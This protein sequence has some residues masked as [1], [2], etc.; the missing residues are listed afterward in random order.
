MTD[1]A[2]DA[3]CEGGGGVGQQRIQRDIVDKPTKAIT[4]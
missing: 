3:Q 2:E 4:S 1:I